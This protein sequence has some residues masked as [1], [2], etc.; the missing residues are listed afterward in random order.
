MELILKEDI[1]GLGYKND[2]VNVKPG[3][4][5]NY[6]IP[7]GYAV[8]ANAS[9]KKV[10]QEN[11][12]QAAHKAEKI[13]KDAADLAASV[14]D[15]VLEIAAKVGESGR[16]FGKV[17]TLQISDAL[18]AKGFAVDRKKISFESEVKS[19]GDYTALLDLHKDIKHRV[20]FKVVAS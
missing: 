7:Q 14:G 3:Y 20:A 2:V 5:R 16:I 10:M 18:K 17:T 11:I 12:K 6:L 4:G 1:A 9:N 19:E 13:K 15:T 8:I